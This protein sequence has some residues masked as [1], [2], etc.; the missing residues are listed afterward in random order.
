DRQRA[1]GTISDVARCGVE[2][3]PNTGAGRPRETHRA[4]T[5]PLLPYRSAAAGARRRLAPHLRTPLGYAHRAARR[6]APPSR[7]QPFR[8]RVRIAMTTTKTPASTDRIHK[9][10]T[11]D[12]P[13]PRVWRAL[14]DVKQF[15]AWSGV[16]L[17][18]PFAPG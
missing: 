16:T 2:A 7:Q 11:L 9:E 12:A 8:L 10:V 4:W 6:A 13:R 5:H 15:N 1:R 18:P 14:T 17:A 3:H